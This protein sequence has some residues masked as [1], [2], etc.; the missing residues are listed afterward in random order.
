MQV[1]VWVLSTVLLK[2]MLSTLLCAS[3]D[4]SPIRRP[5]PELTK[6]RLQAS[7]RSR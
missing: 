6:L 3:D 4:V 7:R 2:L 5:E 1:L